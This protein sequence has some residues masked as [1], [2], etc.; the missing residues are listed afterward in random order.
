MVQ[1]KLEPVSADF[2]EE[3]PALVQAIALVENGGD[4]SIV[5]WSQ[6]VGLRIPVHHAAGHSDGSEHAHEHNH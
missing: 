1:T 3:K 5:Q 4:S 6:A 2:T